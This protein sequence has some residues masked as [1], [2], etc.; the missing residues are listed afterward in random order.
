MKWALL[1]DQGLPAPDAVFFLDLSPLIA[2]GRSGFGGERYERLDFQQKVYQVFQKL[3]SIAPNWH[4]IDAVGDTQKI[5]QE[6]FSKARVLL[7]DV[8][9]KP[10]CPL[11]L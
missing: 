5:H 10:I 7:S 1:A 3:S 6:C 11:S 9:W 2:A 8:Q 4:N